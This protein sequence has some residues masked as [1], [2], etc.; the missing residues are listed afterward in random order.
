MSYFIFLIIFFLQSVNMMCAI[1]YDCSSKT[2]KRLPSLY[3]QYCCVDLNHGEAFILK[4]QSEKM[5]FLCPSEDP[6]SCSSIKF[7]ESCSDIL[8][9]YPLA[10]SGYYDLANTENT[11]ITVYC[12][13]H[14]NCN[15]VK[16]WMRVG[17]INMT[18]SNE[19]CPSGFR[20]YEENGVRACGRQSFG[21][22]A[23]YYSTFGVTY[24]K[25]CGR[26]IGY[27]KGTTNAFHS[28]IDSVHVG[29]VDGVSITVGEVRQ[30]V[31][32]FIATKQGGDAGTMEC[33]C[34]TNSSAIANEKD[35][36]GG[37]YFCESG[38]QER[39]DSNTLYAA[40]PLWDGK[41]CGLIEKECC[42][43]T[44][45]PWFHKSLKQLTTDYIELRVCGNQAVEDEDSPIELFE[46]YVD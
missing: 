36:V 9:T 11:T 44:G 5:Y 32:T 7:L 41:Q 21:C 2:A 18:D 45:I 46:V 39:A 16:G 1:R 28:P 29:Y 10:I 27:Q 4:G 17:Y 22:Q 40:D 8:S 19:Q 33:P 12:N 15:G 20:L 42:N 43:A 24:S 30:H 26:V 6:C 35:F 25:V 34:A 38:A 23:A 31:W 37:D 13:M 3:E 14:L